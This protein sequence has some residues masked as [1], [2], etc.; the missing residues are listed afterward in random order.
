MGRGFDL[1]ER[2]KISVLIML[3]NRVE[4]IKEVIIDLRYR[5][6]YRPQVRGIIQKMAYDGDIESF[7]KAISNRSF[8]IKVPNDRFNRRV[9]YYKKN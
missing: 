8:W 3:K 1:G 9:E 7:G 2:N 4:K 6:D 5:G